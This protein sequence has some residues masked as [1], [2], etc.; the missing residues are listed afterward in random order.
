MMGELGLLGVPSS[1]AAHG[2]GQ[3]RRRPRCAEPD[4]RAADRGRRARGHGRIPGVWNDSVRPGYPASRPMSC[5]RWTAWPREVA[6][7]LR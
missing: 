4:C 1:A 6:P 7:S 5:T 2:P 3:E